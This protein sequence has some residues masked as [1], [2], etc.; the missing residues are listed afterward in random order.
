MPG[1]LGGRVAIVT[2]AGRGLGRAM[3][4]GLLAAGARVTAADLD[5]ASLEEA[6]RVA[7]ERGFGD[8]FLTVTADVAKDEGA[9][10]IVRQTN[11]RFGRLD[12][13]VNN[14]GV[15]VNQLRGEN[16]ARP[17]DLLEVTPAEFR[18]VLEINV[19][20]AFLMTRAVLPQMLA[21]RWGRIVNVTTSLDTMWREGMQ[22]YGASKAANEAQCLAW[23]NELKGTGV[24]VNILVPGGAADT[25]MVTH[26]PDNARA[27]L[28][29]PEVMVAPL[30]WLASEASDGVTGQRFIGARWDGKLP[31]AEAAKAAGA[32]AAWQ[33]LGRQAI[34]P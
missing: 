24:S 6:S 30:M 2:G 33:Q 19:V 31:V 12:I 34:M 21:R 17:K 11:E 16:A 14:A 4:L 8:G 32:P 7:R 10:Q 23:A 28:I 27:K 15:N 29:S 9:P 1:S 20:A 5:A 26:V 3:A 25:R 13:L 18:R 22:P